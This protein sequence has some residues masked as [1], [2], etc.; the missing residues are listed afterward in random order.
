MR[1]RK[2]WRLLAR[3]G[4]AL[5]FGF[6]L[7][8]ISLPNLIDLEN[9]RPQI[10][11]YLKSQVAGEVSVGKLGLA[12]L[13]GPGVRINGVKIFDKFGSQ[14]I[15][16]TTAIVNFDP[17]SLF[18]Q[19][20]HLARLTL[21]QPEVV[22]QLD[23]KKSTMTNF[24]Q[25]SPSQDEAEKRVS[26]FGGWRFDGEISGAQV[27]IVDGSV[28]FTDD[29]FGAAPITTRLKKL[30]SLFLW[31]KN[32]T[33]T[34]FK[35]TALAQDEAGDGSLQIEGTLSNIKFPLAPGRMT[36]DCQVKAKNLNSGTYFP[37][38]QEYVPMHY[39]GGRVDIDANYKGSL[40][41]LFHSQGRITLH[42]AEL[43]YQQ[44]F[45]HK[46]KF[47]RFVVDYDFR[48]ADSYNTIETRDCTI[49]ADGLIVQ[50][51]CLLHEARRGIDGS[52][53]ARLSSGKFVPKTVL[54]LLPWEIIPRQIQG[55]CKH[56]QAQGNLRVEKAY[57]KGTYRKIV[58]LFAENHSDKNIIGGQLHGSNLSV[59]AI[60]RWPSFTVNNADFIFANTVFKVENLNLSIKNALTCEAGVL[61]L[62]NIYH[63]PQLSFA[64]QLKL[65]LP[66]LNPY[67]ETL[68]DQTVKKYKQN[69]VPITFTQG[70]LAGELACK[71]P[72]TQPGVLSWHGVLKGQDISIT[73]TGTPW[74]VEHGTVTFK[75]GD[76]VIQVDS[77]TFDFAGSSVTLR[78]TLPGPRSFLQGG[79]S[80]TDNCKI[81]AQSS[82]VTPALLNLLSENRYDIS[83][84][85]VGPSKLAIDLSAN[86]KDL[87]GF[88]LSGRLDLQWADVKLPF[89]DKIVEKLTCA[90]EFDRRQIVFKHLE[91]Q[92]GQSE[93]LF[94]GDVHKDE[95]SDA[96]LITGEIGS[97]Y[98]AVDDFYALDA[99]RDLRGENLSQLN[100]D[101]QGRIDELVLPEVTT[102]QKNPAKN[103]WRVLSE[104]NFSL[105]GGVDAP[106]TVK[107]C[108]WQWGTERAQA[109]VTGELQVG[110]DGLQGDLEIALSDLDVDALLGID[111]E[112]IS[113]VR[114]S[115]TPANLSE[116]QI[117]SI[118]LE[119]IAETLEPDRVSA[120]IAWKGTLARNDLKIR[121][122]AHHL[123]WRHMLLDK[124][125]CD[126]RLNAAGVNVTKLAGESFGGDFNIYA[127][128]RF[129]DNS[130]M[131][132]SQLD[133]INFENLSDYL[134]NPDRGLPMTG[135]NGS[136]TL[137]LYW[138]GTS[139]ES[140]MRSL[141]GDLDFDFHDGR[142]KR[143]TMIANIC[144]LLNV[145]QFASL[146]LPDFSIDKG[147]PYRKLTCEGLIVGG[148]FNVAKFDMQGPAV[149][150]FGS[151][152]I[153]FINEQ[154]D[155]ELG[156]QP[157]QT[158]DK[159]LA[160][161]PVVGYIITGDNKT[162]VVVPV[163]VQG[164]YNNL[165]VKTETIVGMGKKLGG[166]VQRFFK[167]PVRILRMPGKLFHQNEADKR[168]TG[169]TENSHKGKVD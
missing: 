18:Q 33:Q 151:G 130:F 70:S 76:D 168:S 69:I 23:Q 47:D 60:N 11:A 61:E 156:F 116:K 150:M 161:I 102:S 75:L 5:M 13:H 42:Q 157:L 101:L 119:D 54:P 132:E 79:D 53:D 138:Q 87:S 93:F 160:S 9:Y 49:N 111:R 31:Q 90:A 100:F 8:I 162:F 147:I 140:W 131:I 52:I 86:A 105:A 122:Q 99:P 59:S 82:E 139:V 46:L 39:I 113:A 145:S 67:I 64:G 121:A 152:V 38:Y 167:T 155:L 149:N 142:L 62:Q 134:K 83:G 163:K 25:V 141:D 81:T 128:W 12:F 2:R 135:G 6:F 146:H 20:L 29:C 26:N 16:V 27:E 28:E 97:S 126:C 30:N 89:T 48:L 35:L 164:S 44:V 129:A 153:D 125:G 72:L 17:L 36:L 144:S 137:D 7:L 22:L 166:M 66:A 19:R 1:D 104:L 107:E 136:L 117:R 118:V 112:D 32:G 85:D 108:R 21:V 114:E 98:L 91:L 109:S 95:D 40:M 58:Q 80:G 159:L 127:G 124:V 110:D 73:V 123:H 34:K 154:V 55:Y 10:L 57:L 74:Q 133:D 94:H 56:L 45:S 15:F 77:A 78:A 158:V 51:Y 106:I 43:D 3:C 165:T 4:A 50:G 169:G 143:F 24:F 68:S 148:K 92:H 115:Q 120:L 96:Y 63:N 14:H 103:L 71:G 65:N 37:Y 41:G 88:T 84:F